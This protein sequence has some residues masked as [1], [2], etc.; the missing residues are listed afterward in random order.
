MV[1]IYPIGIPLLYLTELYSHIDFV[2]PIID[3]ENGKKGRMSDSKD[4]ARMSLS[5]RDSKPESRH[6][7]FL[8][9]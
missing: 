9:W 8:F 4:M 3:D 6:L 7:D 2:D 1:F 5:L